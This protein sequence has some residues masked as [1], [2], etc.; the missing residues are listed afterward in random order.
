MPTAFVELAGPDGRIGTW[1][2]ST[3][4]TEPQSFTLP[5]PHV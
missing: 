4:L 5:G 2:V 3:L 1:L